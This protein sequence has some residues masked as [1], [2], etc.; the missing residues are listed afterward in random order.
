MPDGRFVLTL[1]VFAHV[2][3][4]LRGEVE[5]DDLAV[6][7]DHRVDL[8]RVPDV[9]GREGGRGQRGDEVDSGGDR[10]VSSFDTSGGSNP[11]P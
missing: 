5:V 6:V 1:E 10:P 3:H 4:H 7:R 9:P 8:E 2:D 11:T